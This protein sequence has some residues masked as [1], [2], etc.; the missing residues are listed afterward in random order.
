MKFRLTLS[1]EPDH[2]HQHTW[3]PTSHPAFQQ[4]KGCFAVRTTPSAEPHR[5]SNPLVFFHDYSDPDKFPD[6]DHIW[7]QP[8]TS[9]VARCYC[10][11]TVQIIEPIDEQPTI[12]REVNG[13]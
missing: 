9:A 10:G 4:C 12:T 3:Q 2:G 6:H 7:E 13:L 11:H 1:R 5:V 8:L